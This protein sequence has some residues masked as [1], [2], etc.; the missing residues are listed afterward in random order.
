[1]YKTGADA[2]NPRS[3]RGDS[4]SR[5][6]RNTIYGGAG[7]PS[8]GRPPFARRG[9]KVGGRPVPT[10]KSRLKFRRQNY[11][12]GSWGLEDPPEAAGLGQNGNNGTD[13]CGTSAVWLNSHRHLSHGHKPPCIRISYNKHRT[14][15][16]G[17]TFIQVNG[18]VK[19]KETCGGR[20]GVGAGVATGRHE[21]DRAMPRRGGG[22]GLGGQAEPECVYT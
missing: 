8:G 6:D 9:R 3:M 21:W 11:R 10:M 7:A 14:P 15:H 2:T 4:R 12:E 1:M 20:R 5:T 18:S 16:I 22:N 13:S 17:R 19:T